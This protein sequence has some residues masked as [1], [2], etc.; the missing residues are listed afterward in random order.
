MFFSCGRVT[1]LR[2]QQILAF[3]WETKQNQKKKRKRN[4]AIVTEKKEE[5]KKNRNNISLSPSPPFFFFLIIMARLRREE[6]GFY[7]S[8][9]GSTTKWRQKFRSNIPYACLQI[10]PSFDRILSMFVDFST[11][12]SLVDFFM[13]RRI[14]CFQEKASF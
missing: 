4:E 5:K 1:H 14:E 13:L 7:S 9:A 6:T 12:R 3:R 11:F 8:Y 2:C 10:F